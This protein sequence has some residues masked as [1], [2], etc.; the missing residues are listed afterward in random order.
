MKLI[1]LES[2][3]GLGRPGDQVNVKNGFARNYLLPERKA[4]VLTEDSLR[5]LG[6][7][8]VKAEEE[9]RAMISSMEELA[10]KLR[11]LHVEVMARATEEGHL[12]G[13][14]TEKDIHGA[15]VAAGWD[16]A[17]RAIRLPMHL[18]DSGVHE[19]ALHLYGDITESITVEVVPIDM[20]GT[21]I[22]S[23]G[24]EGESA[25]D[26]EDE[27]ARGEEGDGE[28]PLSDGE[29]ATTAEA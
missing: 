14:V 13:S 5:M 28:A 2:V 27:S 16:V 24:A 7:L 10:V 18:K 3:E 8:K 9:E 23:L 4:V 1:L 15:I 11:G 12:F 26:A 22:E 6:K 19:V 21:R 17:Q 25:G 29:P 20:E